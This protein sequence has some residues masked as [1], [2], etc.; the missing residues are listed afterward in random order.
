MSY[1]VEKA[2]Y[3]DKP[4]PR[5]LA[6]KII[7]LVGSRQPEHMGGQEMPVPFGVTAI[8]TG[9]HYIEGQN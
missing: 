3:Q 4:I 5:F 9:E 1:A 2:F 8:H 7:Q 6:E